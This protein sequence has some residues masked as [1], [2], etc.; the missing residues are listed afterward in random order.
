M[1]TGSARSRSARITRYTHSCVRIERDSTVLRA[2]MDTGTSRLAKA[3]II[4]ALSGHQPLDD[5]A[6]VMV[7]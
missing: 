1:T 5:T 3:S 4:K 6:Q 2:G 7:D